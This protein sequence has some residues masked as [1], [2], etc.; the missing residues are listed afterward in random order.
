MY[1]VTDICYCT[2]HVLILTPVIVLCILTLRTVI[3]ETHA[4]V[5]SFPKLP[6]LIPCPGPQ[7]TSC[8]NTF[9]HP[10][11]ID[12]QSSPAHSHN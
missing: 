5:P 10:V 2:C 6:M 7:L 1:L 9:V 4:V 3:L 11:C 12:M 8:T